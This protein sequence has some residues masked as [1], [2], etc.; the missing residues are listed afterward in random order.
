MGLVALERGTGDQDGRGKGWRVEAGGGE[1]SRLGACR[2]KV[3]V[4][5]PLAR[6][7]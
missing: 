6:L 4:N 7:V 3:G 5:D 1:A 2:D